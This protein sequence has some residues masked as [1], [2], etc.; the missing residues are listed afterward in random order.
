MT[1]A[2]L[3][4]H[5]W[6]G[7]FWTTIEHAA[8]VGLI[9]ALAIEFLA[10]KL[11]EPHKKAVEDAKDLKI[12]DLNNETARLREKGALTVDAVLANA[13]ATQANAL[14]SQFLLALSQQL[15]QLMTPEMRMPGFLNIEQYDRIVSKVKPFAGKQFDQEVDITSKELERVGLAGG[16]GAALKKA[17]WIEVARHEPSSV[18]LASVRGV[19]INVDASKD[20]ELLGAAETLASAL[21]A[22]GIAATVNPR[23]E[24]DAIKAN[25]IHIL[26]GPKS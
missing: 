11:A 17:G 21:N 3:A 5:A 14:A 26:V 20:S 12:A 23:A 9:V 7:W 4:D 8:F 25:V 10:L 1:D 16:I 15:A 19:K 22:E 13:Q 6:W 2:E 18:D 24:T